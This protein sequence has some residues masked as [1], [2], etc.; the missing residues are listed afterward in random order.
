MKDRE[1]KIP[2]AGNMF[3]NRKEKNQCMHAL[4]QIETTNPKPRV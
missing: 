3:Y 4:I 1:G 2:T